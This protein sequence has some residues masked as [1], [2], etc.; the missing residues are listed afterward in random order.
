MQNS[1]YIC[2]MKSMRSSAAPTHIVYET[3][4]CY[5]YTPGYSTY[6]HSV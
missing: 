5:A 1:T 4:S 2:I 3:L 6:A